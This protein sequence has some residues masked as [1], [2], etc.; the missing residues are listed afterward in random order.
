MV[1]Y[2]LPLHYSSEPEV[3]GLAYRNQQLTVLVYL[4]IYFLYVF[5]TFSVMIDVVIEM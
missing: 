5:W 2:W 1:L 3:M 4:L